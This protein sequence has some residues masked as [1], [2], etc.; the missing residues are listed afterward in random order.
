MQ[1]NVIQEKNGKLNAL[2]RHP[3]VERNDLQAVSFVCP[4]SRF[5]VLHYSE[6]FRLP[7]PG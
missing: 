5:S 6:S 2:E 1:A 7:R 4:P 3:G